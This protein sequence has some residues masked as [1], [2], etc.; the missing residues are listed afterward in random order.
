[1][2]GANRSKA[3]AD[4]VLGREPISDP[5]GSPRAPPALP[6]PRPCRGSQPLPSDPPVPGA[7]VY[8][9]RGSGS[10][11]EAIS[12][13]SDCGA[14]A[15]VSAPR[16]RCDFVRVVRWIPWLCG[17]GAPFGAAAA[18]GAMNARSA[19]HAHRADVEPV[20]VGMPRRQL[21][22]EEGE[23]TGSALAEL[24][25]TVRA[26]GPRTGS[27]ARCSRAR[28]DAALAAGHCGVRGV[29]VPVVDGSSSPSGELD[30]PNEDRA[31]S[32]CWST[33]RRA[34]TRS[35]RSQRKIPRGSRC[36]AE[37]RALD[38]LVELSAGDWLEMG[39]IAFGRAPGRAGPPQRN[40]ARRRAFAASTRKAK[41]GPTR[42][43]RC[44]PHATGSSRHPRV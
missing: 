9:G 24:A 42:S 37:R 14:R 38:H 1:M 29:I 44:G 41:G 19:G 33:R 36:R 16:R 15:Q 10:K 12:W 30:V 25:Q 18:R 28:R 13:P 2:R 23:I 5:I 22:R 39:V 35:P 17:P 8:E 31:A 21:L 3:P 7:R 11:S 6:V 43:A 40:F 34:R 4:Q 27:T 20:R 32:W 26:G